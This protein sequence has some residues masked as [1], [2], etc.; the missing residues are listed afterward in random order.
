MRAVVEVLP[1]A[2]FAGWLTGEDAGA[3]KAPGATILETKG[4]LG[5]HT[6]DGTPGSGPGF[7]GLYGSAVAVLTNGVERRIT[8]DEAYLRRSVLAPKADLVVGFPDIMPVIP[9]T[10]QELD[11]VVGALKPLGETKP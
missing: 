5:C 2:K 3:E 8:A 1:E 4:C 7:R 11:A 10:P 9:V 6:T